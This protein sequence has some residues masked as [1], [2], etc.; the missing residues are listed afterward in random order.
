MNQVRSVV[1]QAGMRVFASNV[2]TGIVVLT[3]VA[4]IVI[5]VLRV[6]EQAAVLNVNWSMAAYAALG[7]VLLVSVVGALVRWPA[8]AAL[9]RRVDEGAGLKETLS[10]A[11]H[12]AGQNDAWSGAIRDDAARAAGAVRVAQA[13]PVRAPRMWYAPM[14]AALSVFVLW[15][16]IPKFDLLGKRAEAELAEATEKERTKAEQ[17]AKTAQAKVE[18]LIAK[19]E[20][21]KKGE[22]DEASKTEPQNRELKTP[23][24]IRRAAI[25]SLSDMKQKL[26]AAKGGEK[27]QAAQLM[28]EKLKQ[29][30]TPGSGPLTDMASALAKGDISA[31]KS[32]LQKMAQDMGA[33]KMDDASKAKLEEQLNKLAAQMEKVAKDKEKLEQALQKA[34]LDKA[35]ASDPQKMAEAMKSGEGVS[36]E[37]KESLENAAQA[38]Q[39]A[40]EA[41]ANLSQAMQQMAQQCQNPSSGGQQGQNGEKGGASQEMAQAMESVANAMSQMEMAQ[42]DLNNA[43]AALNEA[44]KQLQAMSEGMGQ[45]DSPGMGACDKG[46]LTGDGGF[47]EKNQPGDG[48]GDGFGRGGGG[49]SQGGGGMGEQ[50]AAERWEKIK[51][52][53]PDSG[54]PTIGTMLV[55]GEQV[56]GE[57]RQAFASVAT[58][59]EQEATEAL[60]NNVIE[61]QYHDLVK[62]YFGELAKKSDASGK[63]PDAKDGK[64]APEPTKK[65]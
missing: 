58:A 24:E 52:K 32:E 21:V 18:E 35:L 22:G 15:M 40:S 57:S 6:L 31:A 41:L 59:A 14:V 34:G 42:S 62:H 54:G 28:L 19:V 16:T 55:Q 25:R 3:T 65:P 51:A 64:L 7:G 20:G 10:T 36:A 12:V 50:A 5:G 43:Q 47:G 9:A 49:V 53:T 2:L 8:A 30:R 39:Q 37:Q 48:N 33:G 1:R 61:R 44:Q 27:L 11:L 23:E 26:E 38:Q 46:G 29:L 4:I 56:K 45:C 17:E 13:V 63:K 60:E